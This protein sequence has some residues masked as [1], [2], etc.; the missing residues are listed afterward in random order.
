MSIYLYLL[1]I[2][3]AFS[4]IIR[5]YCAHGVLVRK[6]KNSE[7]EIKGDGEMKYR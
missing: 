4:S 7:G 3:N 2:S 5:M 6:I 1:M